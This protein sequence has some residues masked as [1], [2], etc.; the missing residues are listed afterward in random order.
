MFLLICI[1]IYEYID[2]AN[3]PNI[4]FYYLFKYRVEWLIIDWKVS[5]QNK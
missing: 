3:K 4:L 5:T 1:Y 2:M